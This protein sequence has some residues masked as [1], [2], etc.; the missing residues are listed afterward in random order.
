MVLERVQKMKKNLI[1]KRRIYRKTLFSFHFMVTEQ[2]NAND[3]P[4]KIESYIKSLTNICKS[5]LRKINYFQSLSM[6][7]ENAH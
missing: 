6:L 2:I 3:R 4:A 5:L 7:I 1:R